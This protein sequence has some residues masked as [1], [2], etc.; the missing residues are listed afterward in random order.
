MNRIYSTLVILVFT[1]I[2]YVAYMAFNTCKEKYTAPIARASEQTQADLASVNG[3]I[4]ATPQSIIRVAWANVTITPKPKSGIEKFQGILNPQETVI[5]KGKPKY[6]TQH[7][8][9][10][11]KMF[12]M[13]VTGRSVA[14]AMQKA[15]TRA[16][17]ELDGINYVLRTSNLL[18]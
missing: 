13:S 16:A 7:A 18:V 14:E 9:I 10:V 17:E 12:T 8:I 6:V 15:K 5:F 1:Y 4:K 3:K 2:A 11:G